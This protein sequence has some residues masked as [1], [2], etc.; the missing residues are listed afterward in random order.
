M[1]E[2]IAMSRGI[3]RAVLWLL[4]QVSYRIPFATGQRTRA[5]GAHAVPF[6]YR[7]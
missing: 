7:F 3:S 1:L 6:D 2:L 4:D 5:N